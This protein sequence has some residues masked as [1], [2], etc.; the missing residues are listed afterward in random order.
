[1]HKPPWPCYVS[2]VIYERFERSYVS[3][4]HKH[5]I[6]EWRF[7]LHF[8]L[9][10]RHILLYFYMSYTL[11][12]F[13]NIISMDAYLWHLCSS[14]CYVS[15]FPLRCLVSQPYYEES[16]LWPSRRVKQRGDP[17]EAP[18]GN[19]RANIE[20]YHDA[21]KEEVASSNT[22]Y[23]VSIEEETRHKQDMDNE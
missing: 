23:N 8:K 11:G 13:P 3:I 2:Y 7:D 18:S 5:A 9:W 19:E 20:E 15:S 14:W 16:K 21:T 4:I 22:L 1:M 12:Y 10:K 17:Q 6:N